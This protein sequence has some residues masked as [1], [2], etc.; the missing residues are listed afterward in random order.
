MGVPAVISW[1]PR[2]YL[3]TASNTGGSASAT[4]TIGVKAIGP[5]D[6]FYTGGATEVFTVSKAF[7]IDEALVDE[8]SDPIVINTVTPAL[9]KGS[10]SMRNTA[11]LQA[12]Q[13]R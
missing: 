3:I 10:L 9:P 1:P 4:I 12:F 7:G 2:E 8:E 5:V 11:L 13:L 6:L